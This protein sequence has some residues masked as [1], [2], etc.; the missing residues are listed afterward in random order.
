MSDDAPP[1]STDH[2]DPLLREL[3]HRLLAEGKPEEE[4]NRHLQDALPE[5]TAQGA[6]RLLEGLKAGADEMFADRRR[7]RRR[8]LR[9][10]REK[11]GRPLDL[12]FMLVEAACEAGEEYNRSYQGVAAAERDFV[13]DALRRLHARACLVAGEVL[14][15]MENGYPSGAMARWRTLHEI[16]VVGCFLREQGKA[17]AE[18]YLL[19]HVVD[20]YKAATDFQR[21]CH[22]I[23]YEPYSTEEITQLR[24]EHDK[25]CQQFGKEYRGQWGWAA[26]A[27]KPKS[28][29]FAEI[30]AAIS[31][32]HHR[33]FFKLACH[34]NH[35]GSK[36]IQ[37]D[38]GNSLNPLGSDC[39]LAGPSD[40]GLLDP[41]TCTAVSILQITT[42]LI[43]YRSKRL[44]A[45]IVAKSLDL[46]TD[47]ILESFATAEAELT[48]KA[49]AM[50]IQRPG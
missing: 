41:G 7:I 48:A 38:L 26:E 33:P 42:N 4:I 44:E 2:D 31:F 9:R 5:A 45:L 43:L 34:S 10:Q 12:L 17:V 47:E 50:R 49:E 29:N 18:K 1:F 19:H 13:F 23:G 39:L 22:T 32:D 40:A 36:G 30:E 28:A 14:V 11:W 20:T 6:A 46:P 21:N 35:A 8:F 27:L 3:I 37:F 15:L 24:V 16:A 25:L